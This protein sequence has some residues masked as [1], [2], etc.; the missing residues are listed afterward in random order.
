LILGEGR[1]RRDGQRQM[2][3]VP[4]TDEREAGLSL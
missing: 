3:Q 2:E 1:L 4:A